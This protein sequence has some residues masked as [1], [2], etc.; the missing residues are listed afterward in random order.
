MAF[1]NSP[2]PRWLRYLE[3]RLGWIEIPGIAILLVTLQGLGFLLVS[4][5]PTW[6]G[7]LAL[8]PSEVKNGEFWRL[9]TWLS[10]PVSLSLLWLFF[11]LWFMYFVVNSIESM[12]GAFRTT[13]YILI[14]IIITAVFSLLTGYPIIQASEFESSLFL[15]AAALFPEMEIRLFLAIPVKMKWLGWLTLA[16]VGYDFIRSGWIGRLYLIAIYS[17]YL[18]FFGPAAINSIRLRL[19]RETFRRKMRS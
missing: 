9:I 1:S 3:K 15:A 13:F 19:R 2:A 11:A 10:L 6:V 18:I 14:S 5:D 17:N 12:W 16:M 4:S 8:L 7:R